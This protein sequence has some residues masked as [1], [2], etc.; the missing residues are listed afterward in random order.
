MILSIACYVGWSVIGFG[1]GGYGYLFAKWLGLPGPNELVFA[2]LAGA[3]V[4]CLVGAAILH[5]RK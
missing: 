5:F 4:A 3:G 1:L 2:G